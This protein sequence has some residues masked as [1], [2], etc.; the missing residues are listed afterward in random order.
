MFWTIALA[1]PVGAI[2]SAFLP[3][4]LEPKASAGLTCPV[5]YLVRRGEHLF[6]YTHTGTCVAVWAL[7]GPLMLV[8]VFASAFVILRKILR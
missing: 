1:Y 4:S 8:G 5:L 3:Y 6:Q 7:E 2:I